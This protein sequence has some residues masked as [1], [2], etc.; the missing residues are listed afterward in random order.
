MQ[1]VMKFCSLVSSGFVNKSKN[2]VKILFYLIQV[3]KWNKI[4]IDIWNEMPYY[5][6][7]IFIL[8]LLFVLG[9]I[10]TN[11]E[12]KTTE[13]RDEYFTYVHP[14]HIHHLEPHPNCV[15]SRCA[16]MVIW[17]QIVNLETSN[18]MAW[19]RITH[20]LGHSIVNS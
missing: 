15:V 17:K 3:W 12:T 19:V 10:F 20:Q 1:N 11:Y 18:N 16:F 4:M 7:Y 9:F 6:W 5:V 8:S 2:T 14:C 13:N